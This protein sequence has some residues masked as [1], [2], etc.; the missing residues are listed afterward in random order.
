MLAMLYIHRIHCRVELR[1]IRK[2]NTALGQHTVN[3]EQALSIS[4]EKRCELQNQLLQANGVSFHFSV[5][6]VAI[7]SRLDKRKVIVIGAQLV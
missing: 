7:I 1:D 5:P 4:E 3:V 6:F 2:E